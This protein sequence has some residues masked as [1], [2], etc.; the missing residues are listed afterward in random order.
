MT[1]SFLRFTRLSPPPSRSAWGCLEV[2]YALDYEALPAAKWS[3][4]PAWILLCALFFG[5]AFFLNGCGPE[6]GGAVSGKLRVGVLP[7]EEEAEL[8]D[9]Y[10]P[11]L[12][13]LS[14]VL[15]VDVELVVP[16]DY[17]SMLSSFAAGELDLAN[18][19][20]VT[21]VKANEAYG[22]EPLV[23]RDIDLK[24]TTFFLSRP[25]A[26]RQTIEEFQGQRFAFGSELST[27]GH[28]MPR[29]FM[30]AEGLVP[31]R[32]FTSVE[33]SGSHDATVYWVRDGKVDL[34]AVNSEVVQA[35]LADGRLTA[36]EVR[37]VQETPPY[38]DYV[39]AVQASLDPGFVSRLRNAFLD[40]SPSDD[41]NAEILSRL[42]AG[43]FLPARDSDFT[44]LREVVRSLEAAGR[45]RPGKAE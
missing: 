29:Y 20:G 38:A 35:M 13:Y 42:G 16:R 22:A 1:G 23:L 5:L 8:R 6:E 19:G 33:Y 44:R 27:S 11:L 25:D 28:F 32:F 4:V 7:D 26:L 30:Q 40:L 45:D 17:A 3:R 10:A 24:F 43:G 39:W 14:R 21:F 9:R 36:G 15:D 34:G 37:V 2:G 12:R 18:F 41:R 31:E